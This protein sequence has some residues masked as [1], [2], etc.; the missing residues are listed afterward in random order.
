MK[1]TSL[2]RLAPFL[3]AL[4]LTAPLLSAQ[5]IVPLD[6]LADDMAV[7][8]ESGAS[9]RT[10]DQLVKFEL[11][12]INNQP[13]GQLGLLKFE[14]AG[15]AGQT[16]S[17]ATLNLPIYDFWNESNQ[18]PSQTIQVLSLDYELSGSPFTAADAT[19][20]NTTLLGSQAVTVANVGGT[21]TFDLT[22]GFLAAQAA[23]YDYFAIRLENVTVLGHS[24]SPNFVQANLN[25]SLSVT[26]VPEPSSAGMVC[27]AVGLVVLVTKRRGV[28]AA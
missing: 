8:Y 24:G 1:K 19:S 16:I 6:S 10:G 2:F 15:F 14:I 17:N 7:A 25:P 9:F 4:A 12:N 23:G 28:I 13:T 5:V 27:L 3:L 26:A 21:V 11:G 22:S 20:T 18:F